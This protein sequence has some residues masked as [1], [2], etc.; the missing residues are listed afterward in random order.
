MLRGA[1]LLLACGV[2][3]PL[4]AGAD[5][6]LEEI[7]AGVQRAEAEREAAIRETL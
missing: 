1:L 3:V 7:L 4:G 2:L 5:P 6:G